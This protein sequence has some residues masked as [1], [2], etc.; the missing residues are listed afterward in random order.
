[1]VISTTKWGPPDMSISTLTTIIVQFLVA[2]GIVIGGSIFAGVG[3]MLTFRPPGID[4]LTIA[5]K[6][7][8]WAVV[9]AVGGTIDPI[10]YIESHIAEGYFSPAIRQIVQI[11]VCFLG[12]QLGLT[13]IH[14]ICK[15]DSTT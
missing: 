6:I 5:D 15:G 7:K 11:I 9:A 13:L 10:R 1:M 3:A 14:W 2:F 12:A 4:M 8:I